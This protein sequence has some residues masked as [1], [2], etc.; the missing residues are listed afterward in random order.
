MKRFMWHIILLFIC[1]GI[2][3]PATVN[4]E[5]TKFTG[6]ELMPPNAK[7]GE[8][9]ARVFVPPTYKTTTDTMLRKEASDQLIIEEP[10]FETDHE[11]IMVSAAS[12]R[13]EIIPAEYEMVEEKILI[14]PEHVHLV[15]VPAV[16]NTVTEQVLDQPAHTVWKKGRGLIEKV[17]NATGEIMCLVEIPATYKTISKRVLASNATTREIV[18]PAKYMTFQK[19]VMKSSPTVKKIDIPAEFKTVEIKKLRS[20]AMAKRISTPEEFQ[21]VSRTELLTEGRMEWKAVL[22]ETNA[23]P[24]LIS[25]IQKSLFEA[26]YSPGPVDG[27]LGSQTMTAIRSYQKDK[28]LPVG[29]ITIDTLKSLGVNY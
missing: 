1:V 9:Y 14:Q 26:G 27:N 15:E 10:Q 24:Q 11:S 20:E 17:D 21:T 16:Y 8:C 12:E 18:T 23:T 13:L 28:G 25:S 3:L 29:E 4:A 22:C 7:P 5:A 2:A 6:D 19:R